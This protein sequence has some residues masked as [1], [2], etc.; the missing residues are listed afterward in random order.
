MLGRQRYVCAQR[1]HHRRRRRHRRARLGLG[2][3]CPAAAAAAAHA[4]LTHDD[5]TRMGWFLAGQQVVLVALQP[6]RRHSP[7][8]IEAHRVDVHGRRLEASL[9]ID[10][11]QVRTTARSRNEPRS[12][13]AR[14]QKTC[15][16]HFSANVQACLWCGVPV[17]AHLSVGFHSLRLVRVERARAAP[18]RNCPSLRNPAY[19][20]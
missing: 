3:G 19:M 15:W 4:Q 10:A 5:L 8:P 17:L 18:S 1:C 2:P 20:C 6:F 9:R 7:R 11:C 13:R 12:A 16:R 14:F